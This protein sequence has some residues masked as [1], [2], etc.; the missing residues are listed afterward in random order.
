MHPPVMVSARGTV[1]EATPGDAAA[2]AKLLDV[3]R[4]TVWQIIHGMKYRDRSELALAVHEAFLA[5]IPGQAADAGSMDASA[6]Q[7]RKH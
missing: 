5:D 6:S 1:N 2:I 3:E 7:L 4:E